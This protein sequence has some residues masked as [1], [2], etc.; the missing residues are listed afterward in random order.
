MLRI[1]VPNLFVI[2]YRCI[3]KYFVVVQNN[4]SLYEILY[5]KIS[6]YLHSTEYCRKMSGIFLIFHWN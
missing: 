1:R 2:K 4:H 6:M 5:V 3:T